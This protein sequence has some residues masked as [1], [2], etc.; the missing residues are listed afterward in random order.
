MA[1]R[2][3]PRVRRAVAKPEPHQRE[4]EVVSSDDT[5]DRQHRREPTAL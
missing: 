4:D 1:Q 5:I 2:D 3:H